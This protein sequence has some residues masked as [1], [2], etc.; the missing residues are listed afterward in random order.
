MQL[1]RLSGET[2]SMGS[3]DGSNREETQEYKW[4]NCNI[5]LDMVDNGIAMNSHAGETPKKE[6]SVVMKRFA[7]ASNCEGQE[8]KENH[9]VDNRVDELKEE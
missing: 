2:K 1:S 7:M 9:V 8:C 6:V 5:L 4:G 3:V